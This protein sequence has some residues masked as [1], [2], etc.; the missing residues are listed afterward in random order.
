MLFTIKQTASFCPL[1][2]ALEVDWTS[3][4]AKAGLKRTP[5]DYFLLHGTHSITW[6]VNDGKQNIIFFMESMSV[7]PAGMFW[8][9]DGSVKTWQGRLTSVGE[10]G[11]IQIRRLRKRTEIRNWKCV[12]RERLKHMQKG[13]DCTCMEN[14][15]LTV[16]CRHHNQT[17]KCWMSSLT[18]RCWLGFYRFH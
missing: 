6:L 7:K 9:S 12:G 18:R 4:K 5:V 16:C 1:K 3:E 13:A 15:V 10:A 8:G 2:E 14:L 17:D 11:R